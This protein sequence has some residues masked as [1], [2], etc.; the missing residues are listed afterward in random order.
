MARSDLLLGP[1]S[2]QLMRTA[3]RI[4]ADAGRLLWNHGGSGDDVEAAHP[5]YAVSVLTPTS[6][7]AEPFLRHLASDPQAPGE[8]R[9]VHGQGRFSRQVADGAE[10]QAR[11][12]GIR[13]IRTT[14]RDEPPSGSVPADWALFSAGTF[15]EDIQAVRRAR[16][17]PQPPRVICAVAAGVREFGQAAGDAEGIFGIAQWFPGRGHHVTLGPAEAGFLAAFTGSTGVLPDYPAAQAAAGAILAVH[18]VSLAGGTTRE[19]LWPAA[20]T[21]STVTLFGEFQV[22]TAN[23]TQTRHQ[24][25]LVRW[26]AGKP[27]AIR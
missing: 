5:G 26:T 20:T 4:A 15:E 21:L 27:A 11:K 6:R 24:T 13:T 17:L 23:G 1:Y 3:G 19:L 14:L 2:T 12:L 8:L 22:N 9:I 10:A 25:V 7:Y 18:C 16:T